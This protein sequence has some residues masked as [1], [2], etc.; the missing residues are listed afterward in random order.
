MN[1]FSTR[2][3]AKLCSETNCGV[4][5]FEKEGEDCE[6]RSPLSDFS[7]FLDG[8][9]KRR[10][11]LRQDSHASCTWQVALRN[12]RDSWQSS[13]SLPTAICCLALAVKELGRDAPKKVSTESGRTIFEIHVPKKLA[14][15]LREAF[16]KATTSNRSVPSNQSGWR[17][18]L[19]P[20]FTA[21]GQTG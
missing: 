3:R 21:L 11:R 14:S 15:K 4:P 19:A 7:C 16:N 8:E 12:E 1:L 2:A 10:P 20:C 5:M 6:L 18:S 17:G 9:W 13:T